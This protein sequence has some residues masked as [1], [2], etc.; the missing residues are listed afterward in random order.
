MNDEFTEGEAVALTIIYSDSR[1]YYIGVD[2][3]SSK[4]KKYQITVFSDNNGKDYKKHHIEV[5]NNK[6]EAKGRYE[7][8][9]DEYL[10]M[11]GKQNT[12]NRY[13]S[14]KF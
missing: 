8:L 4:I 14:D 13:I 1:T 10:Q 9:V 7:S 6:D 2:Q 5:I 3:S 12:V 11:A